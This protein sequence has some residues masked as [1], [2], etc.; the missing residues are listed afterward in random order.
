MEG[1]RQ[2]GLPEREKVKEIVESAENTIDRDRP[3]HGRTYRD[4]GRKNT[5]FFPA[6]IPASTQPQFRS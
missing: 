6:E 3:S 5:V 4:F 2:G 1:W